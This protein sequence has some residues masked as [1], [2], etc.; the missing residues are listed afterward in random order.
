MLALSVQSPFDA[1]PRPPERVA[2]EEAVRHAQEAADGVSGAFAALPCGFRPLGPE[3]D[4]LLASVRPLGSADGGWV[5]VTVHGSGEAGH[6]MHLR[7][8]CLTAA[9]R[10]MLSLACDGVESQWVEDELPHSDAF[11]AVGLEL[12][13]DR[14]V[15]LIWCQTED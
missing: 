15:G 5:L 12:G 8:R 9:Q 7:E 6:R 4:A 14:P 10:F 3:A 2:W 13:L 11:R 1:T